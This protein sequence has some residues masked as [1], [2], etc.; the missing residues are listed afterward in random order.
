VLGIGEDHLSIYLNDHL[1]GS[2]TGVRI[3]RDLA[4]RDPSPVFDVLAQEI[5]EDRRTLLDLMDRF[6]AR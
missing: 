4:N 1:M 5:A 2:T 6:G 3:A